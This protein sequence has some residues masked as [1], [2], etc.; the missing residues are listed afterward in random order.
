MLAIMRYLSLPLKCPFQPCN[1]TQ[2]VAVRVF[3]S[4]MSLASF[5][6]ITPHNIDQVQIDDHPG[7]NSTV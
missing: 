5:D 3:S 1:S 7:M 6:G 2:N 4:T